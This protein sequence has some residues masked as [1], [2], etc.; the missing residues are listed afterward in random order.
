VAQA[1]D[2][3]TTSE[4]D[5][6]EGRWPTG[7]DLAILPGIGAEPRDGDAFAPAAQSLLDEA[8]AAGYRASFIG[9]DSS[10]VYMRKS[11]DWWG[12]VVIL[13]LQWLQEVGIAVFADVI[14]RAMSKT[15]DV[16]NTRAVVRV[17]RYSDETAQIDWFDFDGPADQLPN[18][19][20]AWDRTR[21]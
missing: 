14:V 20:D 21:R 6:L 17:G 4:T 8:Q 9:G 13:G 7:L 16:S 3:Q 1:D 11:A 19:L 10:Y 5:L 2:L 15:R 18:A 12:P